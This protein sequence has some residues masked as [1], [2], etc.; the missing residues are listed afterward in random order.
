MCV[1]HHLRVLILFC[2]VPESQTRVPAH[3]GFYHSPG[4]F[5]FMLFLNFCLYRMVGHQVQDYYQQ[6]VSFLE[7]Q[8]SIYMGS[9]KAKVKQHSPVLAHTYTQYYNKYLVWEHKHPDP[10][11]PW[12]IG[13]RKRSCQ[14]HK[15]IPCTCIS[16]LTW[17]TTQPS[18]Y[19]WR[20]DCLFWYLG[21]HFSGLDTILWWQMWPTIISFS[22]D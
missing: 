2:E 7:A 19:C 3:L 15:S 1:N 12:V 9:R 8:G 22:G 18:R 11:L 21:I 17:F 13:F 5:L 6:A 20:M 16:C 14:H 4:Q 10:N